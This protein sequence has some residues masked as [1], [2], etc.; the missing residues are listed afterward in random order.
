M[1]RPFTTIGGIL[2][3]IGITGFVLIALAVLISKGT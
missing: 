1:D 3:T 2:R